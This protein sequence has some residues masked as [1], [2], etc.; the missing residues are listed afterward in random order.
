MI[1]KV[2]LQGRFVEDPELK[3]TQ[4][5]IS[6]VS[7]RIAWSKKYKETEYKC[8]LR[9]TAWRHTAEFVCKYFKKGQEC[10]VEGELRT[11]QYTDKDGNNRSSLELADVTVHFCGPK[12]SSAGAA[13]DGQAPYNPYAP[14]GAA[15]SAPQFEEVNEDDLPF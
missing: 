10:V 4:S 14:A 6:V 13:A 8:F 1:N 3:K 7:F 15:E 9:C 5:E 2:I 12:A 11:E